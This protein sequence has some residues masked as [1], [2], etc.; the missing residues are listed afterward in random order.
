MRVVVV[1]VAASAFVGV[2]VI[3]V[4]IAVDAAVVGLLSLPLWGEKQPRKLRLLRNRRWKL[5]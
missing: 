1:V 5:F 4:V 3:L 2:V